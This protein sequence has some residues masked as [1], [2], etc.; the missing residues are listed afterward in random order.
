MNTATTTMDG[1]AAVTHSTLWGGISSIGAW[2][3]SSPVS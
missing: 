2:D 3:Y 1:G